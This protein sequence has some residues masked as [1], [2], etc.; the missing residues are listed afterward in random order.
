MNV[1]YRWDKTKRQH[2]LVKHELDFV[3]AVTVF[4]GHTLTVE[5]IRF[6]YGER[7]FITIGQVRGRIVTV[8]HSEN[9]D[10][11]RIISMRKATRYE[12]ENY[13]K[14]FAN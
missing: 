13:F 5:D 12:Q 3:D 6:P 10:D 4:E 2:N 8:V 11:I 9:E 7:R 14:T 1:R